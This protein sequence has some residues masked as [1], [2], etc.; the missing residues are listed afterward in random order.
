MSE[1]KKKL[2]LKLA[3]LTEHNEEITVNIDEDDDFQFKVNGVSINFCYWLSIAEATKLRDFLNQNL[4][5]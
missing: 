5:K 4:P 2:E 1:E 3:L